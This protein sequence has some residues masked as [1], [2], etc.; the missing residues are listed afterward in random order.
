MHTPSSVLRIGFAAGGKEPAAY[1]EFEKSESEPLPD[2][3]KEQWLQE[4]T[5]AR[6]WDMVEGIQFRYGSAMDD[7][8]RVVEAMLIL[9]GCMGQQGQPFRDL[10]ESIAAASFQAGLDASPEV[11]AKFN[12]S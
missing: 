4:M 3:P 2:T 8:P 6:G 10:L 1:V 5:E 7:E 11:R 12:R 9:D